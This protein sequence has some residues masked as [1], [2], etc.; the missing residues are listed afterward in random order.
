[1]KI[2][3]LDTSAQPV[4]AAVE[5]TQ[6]GEVAATRTQVLEQTR[7][8][9][10]EIILSINRALEDAAWSLRDIEAIAV[11]IGPGSWTGLRVGL[12]TAKTLAQTRNLPII[13]VP[14]FDAFAL[15]AQN[16][17]VCDYCLYY[18]LAPCRAGEI[19]SK[20]WETRDQKMILRG[21]ERIVAFDDLAAEINEIAPPWL[22]FIADASGKNAIAEMTK[23]LP[24]YG[25]EI[26]E[27]T[28]EILA[29]N[30]ARLA[31]SRLQN[32]QHDDVF[33]LNPLYLAPSSAERVRAEKLEK[34]AR[35]A[36][37]TNAA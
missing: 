7:Q 24:G 28:P 11:G 36:T 6:T 8:L 25:T 12:S 34:L 16:V 37:T 2:L 29:K 10:R 30:I 18:A 3:S 19:Y 26:V 31:P 9:S 23:R 21:A 22:S 14:T 5:I 20:S 15:A 32:G 27:I 13:G 35:E 1:M 4:F 33:A 17:F